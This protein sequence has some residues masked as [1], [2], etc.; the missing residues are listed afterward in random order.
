DTLRTLSLDRQTVLVVTGDHGE[1]LPDERAFRYGRN[2]AWLEPAEFHV[3]LAVIAPGLGDR[4]STRLNSSHLG[5]SYAVFCLK[6]KNYTSRLLCMR[7]FND[8]RPVSIPIP[9]GVNH[10]ISSRHR[11]GPLRSFTK[12]PFSSNFITTIPSIF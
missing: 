3:P 11:S 2:A 8:G 1:K 5:I 4:K 10:L 6:K 12:S 7:L 9:A